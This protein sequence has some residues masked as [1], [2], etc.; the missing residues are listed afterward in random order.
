MWLT[1]LGNYTGEEIMQHLG[2]LEEFNSIVYLPIEVRQ[3]YEIRDCIVDIP[4][5]E[6]AIKKLKFEMVETLIDVYRKQKE[7]DET[8]DESIWFDT[9]EQIEKNSH[10]FANLCGY[11]PNLH[12]PYAVFIEAYNAKKEGISIEK[13]MDWL[14]AV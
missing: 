8:K 5:T 4:I 12:K 10:Y 13:D 2:M 14:D 11:G 9:P 6:E 3:K 7:Y 1:K